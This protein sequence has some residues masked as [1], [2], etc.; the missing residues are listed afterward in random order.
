[1]KGKKIKCMLHEIA[2]Y[3]L[4]FFDK[5]LQCMHNRKGEIPNLD[6]FAHDTKNLGLFIAIF[7]LRVFSNDENI[8]YNTMHCMRH[9]CIFDQF[10]SLEVMKAMAR[11][12]V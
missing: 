3:K 8:N 12:Y 1:M 4:F 11:E 9:T 5:N 6:D 7:V 2:K 10:N